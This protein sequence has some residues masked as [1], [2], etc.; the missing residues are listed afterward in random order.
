MSNPTPPG[1]LIQ[2]QPATIMWAEAVADDLA[3]V[4]DTIAGKGPVG[5]A[6]DDCDHCG[7][8]VCEYPCDACQL[9]SLRV[10]IRELRGLELRDADG[11]LQL[12]WR[13]GS[14]VLPLKATRP[15]GRAVRGVSERCDECDPSFSCFSDPSKCRKRAL[16]PRSAPEPRRFNLLRSEDASGVSGTGLVASG[17]QFSD[18]TCAMRWRTSTSSTSV[19][20]SIDDVVTIHGHNGATVVGWIDPPPLHPAYRAVTVAATKGMRHGD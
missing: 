5:G 10:V 14:P 17:V 6:M 18:G 7:Q 16:E 15:E 12:E 11:E 2:A 8:G 19:Y 3:T 4:L 13:P 9:K 20:A 1:R